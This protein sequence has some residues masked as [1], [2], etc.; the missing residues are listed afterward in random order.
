MHVSSYPRALAMLL[1]LACFAGG[2][3]AVEFDER[4]E[5]PMVK[6]PAALRTRAQ[7]YVSKFSA[8]QAA[9]QELIN[10][11]ALAMERFDLAW[12]I[13]RA[14]DTHRPLGDLSSVGLE[15]QQDGSYRVDYN[16]SPQWNQLDELLAGWLGQVS[17]D[18]FGKQ[19]IDRGFRAED[20]ATLKQYVSTHDLQQTSRREKL[21]LALSFSKVVRKYDKIKRPV[22]DAMVLSY[23]YQREK[24]SAERSRE[25][26]EGLLSALDAQRSRILLAYFGEM[27]STGV[28][29]PSDQRAGIDEQLRLMRL[30]NF[31][32][33]ATSEAAGEAS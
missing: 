9:P 12:Q 32:Q 29:A 26:A 13:Q 4:V 20:V 3:Q 5:A 19:L 33:L 23:I 21:P 11:R 15:A 30:P 1:M 28:W 14:I 6:E 8:L 17:W 16:A 18:A 24:L 2:A 31:E 25:W 10:N 7:L 27:K 22:D